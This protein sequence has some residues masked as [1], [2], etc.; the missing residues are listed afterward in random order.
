MD[1]LLQTSLNA[2]LGSIF[3]IRLFLS[4]LI[5]RYLLL[6][7]RHKFFYCQLQRHVFKTGYWG[8][9]LKAKP[10]KSVF[11]GEW[12]MVKSSHLSSI[13]KVRPYLRTMR[14]AASEK[15]LPSNV[16]GSAL[17]ESMFCDSGY[18]L[19]FFFFNEPTQWIYVW[20]L[21]NHNKS[22]LICI[23]VGCGNYMMFDEYVFHLTS[24]ILPAPGILKTTG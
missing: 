22:L 6:L 23:T 13:Y 7:K 1:S 20:S 10:V 11:L 3:K 17:N 19:R 12:I 9:P 18:L 2:E 24:A 14:S 16:L 21:A 8:V 5:L 4:V 15:P